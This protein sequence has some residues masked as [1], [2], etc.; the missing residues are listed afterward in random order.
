M[1]LT[2]W[3]RPHQIK[4]PG[5]YVIPVVYLS[6]RKMKALQKNDPTLATV[7]LF[8]FWDGKHIV[9]NSSEPLWVQIKTLGH[10]TVHAV[11]DWAHWLEQAYVEAIKQ[12]CGETAVDMLEDDE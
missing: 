1:A 3:R 8:G 9:I 5:G 7:D 10:E 12:E 11:H 6:R 2:Q 4:L